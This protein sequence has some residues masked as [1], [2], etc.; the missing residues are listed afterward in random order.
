MNQLDEALIK[1]LNSVDVS[2]VQRFSFEGYTTYAKVIKVH[3][4]DTVT[5]L[6]EYNGTITK[7]NVRID[8]IDAPELHSKV[9]EEV[10]LSK[11]GK[12]YITN[13]L[14]HTIVKV[15]F[16]EFDKYGRILAD[17]YTLTPSTLD[18]IQETN[19][20]QLLLQGGY[21]R[22]YHGGTKEKWNV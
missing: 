2:T 11:K 12:E 10:A 4:A 1:R 18:T 16:K 9:P 7:Y 6:F 22:A 14:L 15:V 3:D 19:V 13:I 20:A 17:V 8:G 5:L 21:V